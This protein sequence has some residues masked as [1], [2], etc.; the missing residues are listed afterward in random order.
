MRIIPLD[1]RPHLP[2]S[3][4]LWMGDSIGHWESDTLIVDTTNFT[5]KTQL[6]FRNWPSSPD[7]HVVE[8]FTRTGADTLLY[9]ATIDDP[10][11]FTR[12]WTA[13]IPFQAIDG[14]VYE[15]ACHEGNYALPNIL[16][17]ARRGEK[18]AEEA[19]KEGAK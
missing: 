8:R 9:K 17:A 2:S 18:E 15:Y 11:N 1:A 12:S 7:L 4:R 16:R 19:A 3:V 10:S 5:S 6:G 14:V 13:E